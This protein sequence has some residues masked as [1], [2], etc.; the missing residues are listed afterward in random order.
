VSLHHDTDPLLRRLERTALVFCVIA[1]AVAMGVRRGDP[2]LALGIVGGGMLI[3]ISYWAIRSSIDGLVALMGPGQAPPAGEEAPPAQGARA[4]QRQAA[5][6]VLRFTTR[7]LVL[8]VLAYVMLVRLRLDPVGLIV[9]VSSIVVAATL[10]A[11]RAVRPR[12]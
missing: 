8:G 9:G 4:R 11:L 3:G 2:D 1:A 12:G 6:H 7:Y 10:E 5:R